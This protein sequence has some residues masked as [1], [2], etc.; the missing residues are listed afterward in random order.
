MAPAVCSVKCSF[1]GKD[2]GSDPNLT[3]C[4]LIILS[5]NFH[6]YALKSSDKTLIDLT[7]YF[8]YLE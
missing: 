3:F 2:S 4:I 5:A 6:A 1:G 7:V 8:S